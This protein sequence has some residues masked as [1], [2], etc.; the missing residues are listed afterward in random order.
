MEIFPTSLAHLT[1]EHKVFRNASKLLPC[2]FWR[3]CKTER[4]SLLVDVKRKSMTSR[5]FAWIP[6]QPVPTR[7][8]LVDDQGVVFVSSQYKFRKMLAS[9]NNSRLTLNINVC[10][11]L[12]QLLPPA[13]E[14]NFN[15]L[16]QLVSN[17]Q[18]IFRMYEREFAFEALCI[19]QAAMLSLITWKYHIISGNQ[20]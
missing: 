2:K 11:E 14:I 17:H 10:M 13:V 19:R 4:R 7:A 15:H 8:S 16:H 6:L 3:R 1:R 20:Y 18:Q 9:I 12:K 5:Y